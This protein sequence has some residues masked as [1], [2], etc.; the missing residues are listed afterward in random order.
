M[1][2]APRVHELDED[3]AA[4][5][6][7]CVGHLSPAFD[8]LLGVEAGDAGIARSVGGGG[9]SFGDDQA[10][11]RALVVVLDHH[12][13]RQATRSAAPG[14]GRHDDVV[15][16]REGAELGGFERFVRHWEAEGASCRVTQG[17][18]GRHLPSIKI[19]G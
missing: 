6:V 5:G 18:T 7:H 17:E 13:V 2:D 12:V 1:E 9:G 16:E 14:H 19:V 10:R 8:L 4:R 3:M 11:A 15:R